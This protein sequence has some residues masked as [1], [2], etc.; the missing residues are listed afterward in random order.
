M[1]PGPDPAAPAPL[2]AGAVAEG[3]S[4]P[5]RG[6]ALGAR[7]A[8]SSLA[9]V[10]PLV[11]LLVLTPFLLRELG[12]DRYG[13]WALVSVVVAAGTSLDGG[14]GAALQ[15]WFGLARAEGDVRA[16]TRLTTTVLLLLLAA[17]GLLGLAVHLAAP[18]LATLPNAGQDLR[19]DVEMLL[20]GAVGLIALQLG[21]NVFSAQL[22]AHGR[23]RAL[24]ARAAVVQ[25]AHV[26]AVLVLAPEHGLAG[27][28]AA[29][30]GR[31][32]L[33]LLFAAVAARPHLSLR[34]VGL[35]SRQDLRPF[36]AF[37][38]RM[39]VTSLAG[40]VMLQADAL[41]V[42][43]LLPVR[44]VGYY[45]VAA[46][47]A[48]VVR[49]IPL[50]AMTP[51]FSH[52]VAA[53]GRAGRDGA[54][55]EAAQIQRIFARMVTGYLLVAT[56]CAAPLALAWLGPEFGVT[57]AVAAVLSLSNAVGT[58]TAVTSTLVRV[59]GR[60][61][62]ETRYGL[63]CAGLNVVLTVPAT[64]ALGIYGVVAA[65]LTAQV[66]GAVWFV[67]TVGRQVAPELPTF[68]AQA[69]LV[70]ALLAAAAGCGGV[71]A[72]AQLVPS[73]TPGLL[74][75]ALPAAAALL[76]QLWWVHGRPPLRA[77]ARRGARVH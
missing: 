17:T 4:P 61:G 57:A 23:F 65:T 37:A 27:V 49:S 10:L 60:P 39:Q 31:N 8:W 40:I 70:P 58:G 30:L 14:V 51:I 67:R 46:Q 69:P 66:L 36:G 72:V 63:L 55:E 68:L 50:F 12:V 13:L 5:A 21:A 73:G 75:S 74:L 26:V 54:V 9:Q 7:I 35:S 59:L 44:Y 47:L 18:A 53:Y 77:L 76:V 71:L 52:L 34:H 1:T 29:T 42:A 11:T 32:A 20:R 6:A 15:R 48:A 22:E 19:P 33:N 24:A 62:M 56:A 45:G 64:L 43:A 28:L 3:Q 16:A 2:V 38:A 41:V 25:V